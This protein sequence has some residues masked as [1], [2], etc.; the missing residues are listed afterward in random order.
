MLRE[1]SIR[2]LSDIEM[3][4]VSGGEGEDEI[5]VT[6][7]RIRRNPYEGMTGEQILAAI[8]QSRQDGYGLTPYGSHGVPMGGSSHPPSESN[9][10]GQSCAQA[11]AALD[12]A[13]RRSWAWDAFA[14]DRY[15]SAPIDHEISQ[16]R[17]DAA[18][19]ARDAVNNACN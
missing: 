7:T 12:R 11:R 2:E 14:M 4:L 15:S 3:D 5:I 19:A 10:D 17:Q 9:E 18:D 13:N 6:G 8:G 1:L 16:E